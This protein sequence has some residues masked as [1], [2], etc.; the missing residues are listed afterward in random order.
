MNQIGPLLVDLEN[1]NGLLIGPMQICQMK[2]KTVGEFL[3]HKELEG[4]KQNGE[5][6]EEWV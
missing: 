6:I 5:C 4:S 3:S 1:V 2:I